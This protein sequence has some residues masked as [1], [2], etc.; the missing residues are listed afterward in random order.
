MDAIELGRQTATRLH[1]ELVANGVDPDDPMALVNA[2][3]GRRGIEINPIAPGSPLLAGARASFDPTTRCIR[4]ERTDSRFENAFLVAHELG[5]VTLG[6]D[7]IPHEAATIDMARPVETAPVGEER[8]ADYSRRTRR[9]VQMDLFARELLLPRKRARRLHLDEGLTATR[10]AGKLGAPFDVVAQQLLDAL[11]LPAAAPPSPP[12]PAAPLNG[13]Q[14]T[15]ADHRGGAYLLEA[16][17]GTGKTKTLVAR[18]AALV[19][20][21]EDPRSIVVLTYSNRAAAELSERLAAANAEAAAAIW[22][23]TFHAYGLNLMR[24]FHA[25]MGYSTEPRLIDRTDAIGNLVEQVASLDLRHY[26]NLYDP[27]AVLR[28]ILGAISRAQ[29]EVVSVA[30]Y[31]HLAESMRRQAGTDAVALDAA[32]RARE[33]AR[34]YRCYDDLKRA[35]G[36][37]DFG[38]LVAGCVTFLEGR[39]DVRS[40]LRTEIRHVL[41][42][43]YQDVNRASVRLLR[44][45]TDAG[46]NLWCVG[47]VRQSIYRFRGASS[48][49]MAHFRTVDFP[50]ATG[51]R[52]DVNYRSYKEIV[53]AYSTFADAMPVEGSEGHALVAKR[54]TSAAAVEFRTVAGDGTAEVDELAASIEAFRSPERSYRDQAIL[55]SG[56]DRL[57]RIALALEARGV[58]VLYLG[59][60]FERPEVRD[61]LSWLSLLCDPRAMGLARAAPVPEL[62]MD[63]A[64][65]ATVVDHARERDGTPLDWCRNAVAAGLSD[66]ARTTVETHARIFDG[67][68]PASDPWIAAALFLL[69]RTRLAATLANSEGVAGR[70]KCIAV[71]QF[72][73]FARSQTGGNARVQGLLD[74]IRRISILS[75]EREMRNLPA[76]AS[77][78]DAVRLMTMHGSKGL[79]F[80]VVHIPGM[81]RNTLPR[82]PSTPTC[83]PP[84]GMVE[85]AAH[86]GRD[87]TDREHR[88]EQECLF[89]VALSRAEDRLVLYAPDRTVGG[90]NRPASPFV[91]RL[92]PALSRTTVSPPPFGID[93]SLP[94]VEVVFPAE[95]SIT[96]AQLALYERCPRRYF[97]AHVL[98][99]GGRRVSTAFMDMH[100]VVRRVTSALSAD[101]AHPSTTE[102]VAALLDFHWADS[103][104]ALV[105]IEAGY[106]KAAEELLEFFLQSRAG[107]TM[108][109]PERVSFTVRNATVIVD[110]EETSVDSAGGKSYRRIRTGHRSSAASKQKAHDALPI[111][112]SRVSP[113]SRVEVIFLSDGAVEPLQ[114][115][116]SLLAKRA[117]EIE[118]KVSDILAG[119]FPTDPSVFQCPK[120]PSFFVCGPL[121]PGRLEKIRENL[122]GRP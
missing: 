17:P 108:G 24:R 84:A 45:I 31:E 121:P 9:E 40:R 77:G 117:L 79:E 14:Q 105:P 33:V 39:A 90:A 21:G 36:R 119:R 97:Y 122:P 104:L 68:G 96:Q 114:P 42:D 74:R 51:S 86:G 88:E 76:S 70:A 120:C 32:E 78:I 72:M 98:R 20:E 81:N 102:A 44:A 12:K 41:V 89:Y 60:I 6:D 18:V 106:R 109:P 94:P 27:T 100:E 63:I 25:Q 66:H 52:L 53:D 19:A 28:D 59:N 95:L 101:P 23:G 83:P 22:I 61:L 15:A 75:D 10:I 2:E 16:G 112:V 110:V 48:F 50:G 47:D 93:E 49:N 1:D 34:V 99:A 4:H 62:V 3:A 116:G 46:R 58:P 55:C 69:D 82:S 5:H 35:L 64:D 103:P 29:D 11:L 91:D 115:K 71:W 92:S 26:R 7:R 111:A 43:E 113:G 38:D 13:K 30:A 56:N 80:P 8:V 73:N 107:R 54:G 37:V 67:L 65:V 87:V 118:S 57:S 85:G